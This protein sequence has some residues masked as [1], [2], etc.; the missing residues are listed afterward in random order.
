MLI[1][2]DWHPDIFSFINSKRRSGKTNANISV[3]VSDK[4]MKA[5]KADEEWELVFPD[6]RDPDFDALW[7]VTSIPG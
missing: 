2:N 7:T 1:L 6:T 4:L 3:G 5:V